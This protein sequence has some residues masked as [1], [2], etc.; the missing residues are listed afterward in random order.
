MKSLNYKAPAQDS[1][2]H[3]FT[4]GKNKTFDPNAPAEYIRSFAIRRA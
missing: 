4:L 1:T 2:K 3:Q